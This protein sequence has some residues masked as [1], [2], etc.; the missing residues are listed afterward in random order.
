MGYVFEETWWNI[1]MCSCT[2]PRPVRVQDLVNPLGVHPHLTSESRH[3]QLYCLLRETCWIPSTVLR[4]YDALVFCLSSLYA[5]RNDDSL[6]EE[7]EGISACT[8][9]KSSQRPCLCSF[10]Q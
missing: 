5:F 4:L 2:P 1:H 7:R 8:A 9:Y 10:L 6:Q 3:R